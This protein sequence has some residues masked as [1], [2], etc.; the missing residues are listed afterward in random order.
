MSSSCVGCR[1][2]VP[3]P[4]GFKMA[5]QPIVDLKTNR[6]WGYEA[7][8]NN[9]GGQFMAPLESISAKGWE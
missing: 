1:E 4:F 3:L 2:D 8:V 6:V 7:L 9:A 5:F